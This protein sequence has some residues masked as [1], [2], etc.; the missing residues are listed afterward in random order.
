MPD[1]PPEQAAEDVAPALVGRDHAVGEQEADRSGVVGHHPQADVGPGGGAVGD[2]GEVLR[3][4]QDRPDD[5]GVEQGVDALEHCGQPFQ[6]GAGVDAPRR[7]V[8]DH[9]VRLVLDVLH[10]HQVPHLDK[11]LLVDDRPAICAVGGSLVVEDLRAG[12]TRAG[13]AHLPEVVPVSSLH[14]V[15]RDADPVD[16]DRLGIVVGEVHG[17][18]QAL[19]VEPE[20]LGHQLVGPRD[21]LLLEVVPKREVA[22]H[23][24]EGEVSGGGADDV[25]VLGAEALLDAHRPRVWRG[26]LHQQVRLEGNHPG[27]GEEKARVVRDQRGA[28]DRGVPP[29]GEERRERLPDLVPVHGRAG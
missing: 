25:D 1:R 9:V 21:R 8:T 27:D 10:E 28:G 15:G 19:R 13:D 2:P 24:E 3:G 26:D 11:P 14:P 22:Q 18:P 20:A 17:E 12:P 5:V 7:Q 23:L 6:P 16:P 29:L 4:G